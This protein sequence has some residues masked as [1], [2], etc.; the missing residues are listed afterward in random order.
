MVP[1]SGILEMEKLFKQLQ[2]SMIAHDQ[3]NDKY[4][5]SIT[6]DYKKNLEEILSKTNKYKELCRKHY[7]RADNYKTKHLH[8]EFEM[9]DRISQL[10]NAMDRINVQANKNEELRF[11]KQQLATRY[12]NRMA[13][14]EGILSK[15]HQ[16]DE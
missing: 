11:E 8:H 15:I 4:V 2:K 13:K 10:E 12:E 7:Y 3:A 5:Q 1:E 14:I 6:I 16:K 9:K